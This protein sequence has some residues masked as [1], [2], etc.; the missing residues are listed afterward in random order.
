[1]KE[2]FGPLFKFLEEENSKF[3]EPDWSNECPEGS[4]KSE[5]NSGTNI[6][7]SFSIFIITVL[8]QL[9]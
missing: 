7:I 9:F 1:M 6:V 5:Y 2:Y 3:P 4:F 8:T